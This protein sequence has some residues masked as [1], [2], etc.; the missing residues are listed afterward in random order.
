MN[1]YLR[2]S[3]TDLRGQFDRVPFSIEHNLADHPLLQLP[4]LIELASAL[5]PESVEYNAG[6]IPVNQDPAL[7]PHTGLSVDETLR[8][9]ERC[10]SWMVLKYVGQQ[11]E[12]RQLLDSCLDQIQPVVNDICPGMTE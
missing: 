3:P 12:Y 8:R 9:I 2:F 4:R 11:P 6:D 7:T 5:P 10:N 1:E